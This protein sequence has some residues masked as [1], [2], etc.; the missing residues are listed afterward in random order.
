[1]QKEFKTKYLYIYHFQCV[2]KGKPPNSKYFGT[3][4]TLTGGVID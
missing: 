2:Y 4:S 3:F 1:M